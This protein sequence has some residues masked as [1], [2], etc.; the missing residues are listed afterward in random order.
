M[1]VRH[2]V[3]GAARYTGTS[4]SFL[5]KRRVFGG[6]P[7]YL[8]LGRKVLYDQGDLDA[9]MAAHKRQSTSE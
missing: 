1:S 5:N 8:K 4:A 7:Q 6:G 3:E 9:W 2:D